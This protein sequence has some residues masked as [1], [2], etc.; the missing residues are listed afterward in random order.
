MNRE[1]YLKTLS[2]FQY[3]TRGEFIDDKPGEMYQELTNRII[4]TSKSIFPEQSGVIDNSSVSLVHLFSDLYSFR[5]SVYLMFTYNYSK[6]RIKLFSTVDDYSLH[7]QRKF[8]ES[9]NNNLSEIDEILCTLIDPE[10][11]IIKEAEIDYPDDDLEAIDEEW[12]NE[13]Q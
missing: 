12:E 11:K 3:F 4:S 9:M 10:N 2:N 8:V 13:K 5:H 7:L 1:E 6:K